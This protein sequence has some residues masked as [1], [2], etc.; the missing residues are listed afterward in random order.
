MTYYVS[1]GTSN[2]THSLTLP[3]YFV[4]LYVL[5][6]L[7]SLNLD[8]Y[9]IITGKNTLHEIDCLERLLSEITYYALSGTLN[10]THLLTHSVHHIED[11]ECV[12]INY[13]LKLLSMCFRN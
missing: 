8:A 9:I 3:S 10:S 5:A 6:L 1:I 13:L 7:A 11:C 4:S 2:P 12:N